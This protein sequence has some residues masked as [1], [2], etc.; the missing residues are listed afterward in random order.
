MVRA[1]RKGDVIHFSACMGNNAKAVCDSKIII[2]SGDLPTTNPRK[3]NCGNC[4]E[5][6]KK[7]GTIYKCPK[8]KLVSR[9][10][11]KIKGAIKTCFVCDSKVTKYK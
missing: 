8:C 11:I 3:V 9:G 6:M 4:L 10:E 1:K 5:K 2:G 7:L